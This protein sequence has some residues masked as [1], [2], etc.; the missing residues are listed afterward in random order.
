M[1]PVRTLDLTYVKFAT[2]AEENVDLLTVYAIARQICSKSV[3]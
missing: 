3:D 1:Y 2:G